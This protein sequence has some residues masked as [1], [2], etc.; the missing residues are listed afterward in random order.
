[1]TTRLVPVLLLA[2]GWGLASCGSSGEGEVN[3]D[4]DPALRFMVRSRAGAALAGARVYL[5][6]HSAVDTTPLFGE[7][8]RDGTAEAS[9]ARS[10]YAK[11]VGL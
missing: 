4:H 3:A 1:M 11:Y 2:L 9:V 7:D 5:V 8:V 10:L 6:P